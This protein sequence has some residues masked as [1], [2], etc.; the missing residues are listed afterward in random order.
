MIAARICFRFRLAVLLAMVP[1]LCPGVSRGQAT[2]GSISGRVADGSGKVVA[3]AQ[4]TIRNVDDGLV[5]TAT[6]GSDGEFTETALPPATYTITVEKE[7]F[8]TANV[9]PF[10]LDI[11]QKARFN[12]PLK[13]G[14]VS[15]EVTVTDSA[16]V[17]QLQG[18][19]TGEVIGAKE[20]EDLP[21]LS[22]DFTSLLLL[23]PGVTHGEGGNNINISVNG[24]REFANSIQ[25]NGVE[26]TGTNNDTN[27]RPSPDAIQEFKLVTSSYAPEFGRSASGGVLIQT[28]SGTNDIHGT[29]LLLYR[30]TATAANNWLAPA[31]SSPTTVQ[32]NYSGTVGGPIKKD[33]AFLFLAYEGFRSNFSSSYYDETLV[34][35]NQ[36]IYDA[37][38]DVDLSK[39]TDPYTGKQVPIFDPYF[40]E[41]N[42]YTEQFP[43]NVIPAADVSPAGRLIAQKLYPAP[44]GPL[45]GNP[46]ENFQTT[47]FYS[48]NSN[49]GNMRADYT[50]SQNN[51]I[52]LTYDA[53]QG[54]YS[55][56][57]PY[58]G[59]I[60]I[61]GGGG[62]DSGFYES[63]EN[64]SM[65]FTYDHV[66]TQN[67]L[68]E[69]R[70][71]YFVS[72]TTE[73]SL[74]DGTDLATQFGIKNANI[75]GFPVT[76]GFPQIQM[77]TGE[78]TG[79]S[80]YKPLTARQ[81]VFGLFDSIDYVHGHHNAKFGYEYRHLN[82]ISNYTLFPVPYE[83]FAGPGS[84]FTS[85]PYYGYYDPNA[86][87]YN[88]GAEIAD[89]LLGLPEVV[90][91]GLQFKTPNTSFNEQTT[92]VQ[93]YWQLTP[94]LNITYGLRYEYVQPYVEASNNQSDFNMSTLSVDLAGRGSNSRSLVYSNTT[95]L[96][97]RVG[98]DYMI[99]SK[100][101][102]RGG[103]GLFYSPEN[104]SRDI[105]LTENYPFYSEQYFS[106]SAYYLSYFLDSGVARP[107][108]IPIAAGVSSINLTT[109]PGASTQVVTS[110]PKSFPIGYSKTYN[111]TLQRQLSSQMSAQ[112]GFV[113]VNAR[114]LSY[115]VGNYNVNDHLSTKLG[116]V[117]T[118]EPVG[119]SNY[120]S[121][122]AELER[123]MWHG[124]GFRVS[125]TWSHNLDNGPAPPNLGKGS[126]YPQSPFNIASEYGNSDTDV[127]N[128]FVASQIIELPFGKGKRFLHDAG[129]VMNG[130]L[131][132]WQLN[133]ITTLQDGHPFNIVSNAG[134][135][136]Y[137]GLRPN[138][139]GNPRVAH[140]T[141]S[142]WFNTAAFV[143]PAGQAA[144]TGAGKT[145][146]PGNVAR[147]L[148]YGPG[149]SDE[150]IS[151]F[152]SFALPREMAF[153][154]RVEAFNLLNTARYGQPNGNMQSSFGE[155]TQSSGANQRVM[156]FAGRFTF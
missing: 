146:I 138:V 45:A 81:K 117:N 34:G 12:L 95:D 125:Y 136:T 33:K 90:Y 124:Y 96:M 2:T 65:A 137:P 121:L 46:Y 113:G 54:T 6:T 142:K 152:K 110:E 64:N 87:Y 94:R 133:S 71:T 92:Y 97:P 47:Q 50:F 70:A 29:G 148:L 22:R 39:L 89:L 151:L 98:A 122:Q 77:G 67:L 26:V 111:L 7:G 74:V 86:F 129:G 130:F 73:K 20:I 147:N 75:A 127:R 72:P 55:A 154:V 106:N 42:Y 23:V 82:S 88:G 61:A 141:T 156:Q 40:F 56:T 28:K 104:D 115:K 91:Q 48:Q 100:M 150:D 101:V 15:A 93:D 144:S 123:R 10:K 149:Y 11:D 155:I 99:T 30:P 52:Y 44:R 140:A 143:V 108:S 76:Y 107:T 63:Y 114:N 8:S 38:G 18:A 4:V 5:T 14:S 37:N 59:A 31:G 80:T 109:V 9:P 27:V 126:N 120:S 25:I 103:F 84:N 16:P 69:A 32:K 35:Q 49:T 1:V 83:Y 112:V 43:G 78:T 131:G 118:L 119:L 102:V 134:N 3:G 128:V 135:P 51:R 24:Q 57:D 58:S 116:Q 105:L 60:P 19:E 79:G 36:A 145:L 41:N 139:T 85:D 62:A 66:F 53:E 132:G 153:Q 17:L 68:N 21:T 13:V